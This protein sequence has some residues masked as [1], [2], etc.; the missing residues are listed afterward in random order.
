MSDDETV[1][2]PASCKKRKSFGRM[3]DVAKKL[4]LSSHETGE[5]CHCK[6][7]KCFESVTPDIRRTLISDFNQIKTYDEQSVYLCGLIACKP[8]TRHRPRKPENDAD[9]HSYSYT[10]KVR[11][12]K[13]NDLCEIPVCYKVF[14]SLHGITAKRV[15]TLQEALKTTGK[16]PLDKRGKHEN[17][18]NKILEEV[19]DSVFEH[20]K[21]F[22]ARQSHY[23]LA[24]SK[25][26]YLPDD[27]N[28]KKMYNM[29]KE[30][31]PD[32]K[33]SYE[34]YREIFNSKFNISF[35]Y[36]R[37]D[38][39]SFCDKV[40]VQIDALNDKIKKTNP[41][42]N[43]Y[44]ELSVELE[45]LQTKKELHLRKAKTF[46][47]RKRAARQEAQKNPQK[48]AIAMDFEKNL[49][50]PNIQTNDV[51][52][53]RQL[54]FYMFNVHVLSTAEAVFYTYPEVCG[55][56]GSDD[57]SSVLFDFIFN[58]LDPQV[59]ELTIFCDSCGGQNKNY[60]IFR[61]IH[62]IV[63]FIKRLKSIK[64][65]FPVRGHSYL[66]CDRNMGLINQ[67]TRVELPS[68]WNSV[69]ESARAK[70]SPFKVVSCDDQK[71]FKA[72]SKFLSDIYVKKCPFKSRPVRECG[73]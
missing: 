15:Q 70:P 51:Y 53:R 73:N 7:L 65:V 6:K 24:K 1:S 13:N 21:S 38:T 19:A 47:D 10:Y 69:V 4:C 41:D 54:S 50:V 59:E 25:K 48:E 20:I 32:H 64:L 11:A 44:K 33:V 30:K 49:P 57:V 34:K 14:L 55:K 31:F 60:T 56:K 9:F 43:E 29:Y 37:S 72:W 45:S 36:P 5:D 42:L 22:Q 23:S 63:H 18:P 62:Y 35:G 12:L 61:L 8:V 2:K 66:E 26:L 68:E 52:Y 46:Y 40:S 28:V 67:K 16:A 3:T 58:H 71:I 27:L 39:C 17:R